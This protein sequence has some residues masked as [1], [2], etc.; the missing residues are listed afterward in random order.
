M[1]HMDMQTLAQKLVQFESTHERPDQI[2]RCLDFCV[3]QFTGLSV[4]IER[5]RFEEHPMTVISNV[6]GREFDVLILGHIDTVPGKPELFEGNIRDGKLI[7]RGTLDMKAFVATSITLLQELIREKFSGSV[8]LAIVS[9][10]ELGGTFGAKRLVN[11]LG[12]RAKVILVPDDGESIQ[13]INNATKHILQLRFKANGKESHAARPWNGINAIDLL[14]ETY[15][16]L[17]TRFPAFTSIPTDDWVSTL[18]LGRISGGTATNE[19]AGTAEM[20]IDIRF[21]APL[22]RTAVVHEIEASLVPGVTYEIVMEGY[23]TNLD[24]T[25]PYFQSYAQAIETVTRKP[26]EER[27]SGGGTDGRYFAEKGMPVI[28]HQGTGGL[29]QTDE[30]HIVLDTLPELVAIQKRFVIENFGKSN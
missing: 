9:D 23:P 16:K 6:P 8:A 10:E 18:S 28:V 2:D 13:K 30:E 24:R 7:G 11:E 27:R 29:C 19:V 1:L 14:L 20:H 4:S 3:E 21:V 15:Q 12:Y 25:H 26:A 22:T 5:Y 17:R